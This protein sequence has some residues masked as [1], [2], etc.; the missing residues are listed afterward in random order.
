MV[1][2]KTT[3]CGEKGENWRKNKMHDRI[4]A[5][6]RVLL[7]LQ[8]YHSGQCQRPESLASC[9]CSSSPASRVSFNLKFNFLGPC[10]AQPDCCR[11]RNR[12]LTGRLPVFAP[13]PGP[14]WVQ[15]SLAGPP[16]WL[17]HCQR[18]PAAAGGIG[19]MVC[20]NC[21]FYIFPPC[22]FHILHIG[23]V[24]L[25]YNFRLFIAC[26]LVRPP[27]YFLHIFQKCV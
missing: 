4:M 26:I 22:F 17:A 15:V 20:I 24:A 10:H 7:C 8:S 12:R 3:S 9:D 16:A 18:P 13:V 14:G 1:G 2:K 25:Y 11:A 5:L 6:P 21:I 23:I 27:A 19:G